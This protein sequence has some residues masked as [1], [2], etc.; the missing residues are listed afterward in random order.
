MILI[1]DELQALYQ[2]LI[3]DHGRNPRHF[4]KPDT[5]THSQAG[6]NP[7][8]GDEL[9]IYLT[10]KDNVIESAQFEGAGCAISMASASMLT[11][12]VKGKTKDEALA[13]FKSFHDLV[14][15]DE[16]VDTENLGKLAVLAGVK[17]FPARVKCA[18]LAWHALDGALSEDQNQPVS[19]E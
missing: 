15:T 6:F 16:S 11:G 10:V 2:Q 5:C 14:T 9:T 1:N 17:A 3:L 8:C 12:L 13:I 19:T 7:L 18:T 4:G